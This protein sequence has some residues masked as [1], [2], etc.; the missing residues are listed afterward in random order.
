MHAVNHYKS[1]IIDFSSVT[2]PYGTGK[3]YT[4]AQGI[5]QILHQ[6]DTRI[7]ICTHSNRLVIQHI[8]TGPYGKHSK[9]TGDSSMKLVYM[10]LCYILTYVK[11]ITV[12]QISI[13][14]NTFIRM[15]KQATVRP[16]HSVSTTA[17]V[18][19]PQYTLMYS[20]SD[21]APPLFV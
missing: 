6:P 4:L 17:I 2:G 11:C 12:Q 10:G 16:D 3:T 19:S 1:L 8:I 20:R 15:W 14:R 7:L 9:F 5:K 13:S 18:G 21:I